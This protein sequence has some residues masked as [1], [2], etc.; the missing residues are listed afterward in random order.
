M[1]RTITGAKLSSQ[2]YNNVINQVNEIIIS[3]DVPEDQKPT[4][5]AQYMTELGFTPSQWEEEQRVQEQPLSLSRTAISAVTNFV[6][7]SVELGKS[8]LNVLLN[9]IDTLQSVA[10]LA[11]GI[12]TILLPEDTQQRLANTEIFGIPLINADSDEMARNVGNYFVQQYG[13]IDNI[14]RTIAEDPAFV[15]ADLST[16]LSGGASLARRSSVLGETGLSRL[17]T[18]DRAINPIT[19]GIDLT[20]A[21]ARVTASGTAE[22]LGMLTGTGGTPIKQA[23]LSSVRGGMEAREFMRMM[24]DPSQVYDVLDA[25]KK[26]LAKLTQERNNQYRKS[27]KSLEGESAILS[28][29]DIDAVIE[30]ERQS[31]MRGEGVINAGGAMDALLEMEKIINDWKALD[32]SKSHTPFGMDGLKQNIGD[33][34]KNDM[35]PN[36]RRVVNNVYRGIRQTIQN[37]AP[38]YSQMMRHYNDASEAINEIERTLSLNRDALPDTALRK[39]LSSM[40]DGVNTNFG[41]RMD[42][43]EQ[44]EATAGKPLAGPIA[45][46]AMSTPM[47]QGISR[48]TSGTLGGGALVTGNALPALGVAA[49][50]SPRLIGELTAKAGQAVGAPIAAGRK[51]GEFINA[52][53]PFL[54]RVGNRYQLN[55]VAQGAV[56]PLP[57]SL[58]YQGGLLG[59]LEQQ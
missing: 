30:A 19:A 42:L 36:T 28:F 8:F 16:V 58:A 56:Q 29:D 48:V 53:L 45:G 7:S 14:K 21:A 34:L 27:L 26:A 12:T 24:R 23:F 5:V 4:I 35:S 18:I 50:S 39:L 44:L 51:A 15:L 25:A 20:K 9:P 46:A 38:E 54:G 32:P 37:Q 40:R 43:I 17:N 55:Q 6:P 13:G 41:R 59:S 52:Q 49:L 2:E 57:I 1:A 33:F 10:Q 3:P 11:E 31:L 22:L 47:P